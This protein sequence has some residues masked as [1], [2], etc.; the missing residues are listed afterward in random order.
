MLSKL[1]LQEGSVRRLIVSLRFN[2]GVSKRKSK[3]ARVNRYSSKFN[4]PHGQFLKILK[5][6][7]EANQEEQ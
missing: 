1:S 7:G 5:F 4:K 6:L 2:K 3:K